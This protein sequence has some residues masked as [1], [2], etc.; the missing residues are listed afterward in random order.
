MSNLKKTQRIR[1]SLKLRAKMNEVGKPRI[2]ISRSNKNIN[3]QLIVVEDKQ[4][5]VLATA[6]SLEKDL[7]SSG[8]NKTDIAVEV[9]KK[10]AERAVKAGVTNVAFDRAGYKYHGRIKA[11][12]DAAREGGM[13]F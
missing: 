4:H 1:R 10:L 5:K 9:G 12:A 8:K 13:Q 6:S 3:A 11:L 7:K 2:T